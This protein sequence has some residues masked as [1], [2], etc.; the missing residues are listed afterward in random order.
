MF[1]SQKQIQN[2]IKNQKWS[3]FGKIVN[4][5]EPLTVSPQ[6]L[7]IDVWQVLNTPLCSFLNVWTLLNPIVF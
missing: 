4:D 6:N 3:F 5:F 2:L 7:I 1:M